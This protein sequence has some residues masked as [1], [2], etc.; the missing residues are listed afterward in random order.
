M[1]T[2]PLRKCMST[3]AGTPVIDSPYALVMTSLPSTVTRTMTDRRWRAFIAS[4]TVLSIAAACVE[5]TGGGAL[6]AALC[7]VQLASSPTPN[8]TTASRRI[9]DT[10]RRSAT[11]RSIMRHRQRG[12]QASS[13]GRAW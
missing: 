6:G 11:A 7:E 10:S 2:A 8:D 13:T 3:V 9:N 12:R 4:C 1:A 5:S